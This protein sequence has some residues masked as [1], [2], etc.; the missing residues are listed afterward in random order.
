MGCGECAIATWTL[1]HADAPMACSQMGNVHRML[2][3][4]ST[5][6]ATAD[7]TRSWSTIGT[8]KMGVGP[9]G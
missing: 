3:Q 4:P 5:V 8:L 7:G 2:R 6:R 1:E 9:M